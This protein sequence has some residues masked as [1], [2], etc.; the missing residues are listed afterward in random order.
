[1]GYEADHS[2]QL[3]LR[4]ISGAILP[5]PRHTQAVHYLHF[6]FGLVYE[7]SALPF[8]LNVNVCML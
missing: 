1:M 2:V 8:L 5:P 6:F 7:V 4:I 3:L